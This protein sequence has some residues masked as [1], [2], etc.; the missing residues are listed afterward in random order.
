MKLCKNCQ[1]FGLANFSCLAGQNL[2]PDPVMGGF[3][4]RYSASYLR[5]NPERCGPEARWFEAKPKE[6]K[7]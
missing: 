7:P 2:V 4:P 3:A 5:S 6:Q 1:H